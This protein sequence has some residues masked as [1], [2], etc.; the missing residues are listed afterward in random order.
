M[1]VEAFLH[2]AFQNE[3]DFF[4]TP[5]LL[6]PPSH[7]LGGVIHLQQNN[8]KGTKHQRAGRQG[9]ENEYKSPPSAELQNG[10]NTPPS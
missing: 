4:E 10:T 9:S 5:T 8:N 2:N 7:F 1:A 3:R 6:D